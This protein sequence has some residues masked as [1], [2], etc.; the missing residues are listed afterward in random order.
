MLSSGGS[1]VDIG[2]LVLPSEAQNERGFGDAIFRV[3]TPPFKLRLFTV[4]LAGQVK[5]PTGKKVF[6]R[7][8]SMLRRISSSRATSAL[9]RLSSRLVTAFTVTAATLN[10]KTDGLRR[11]VRAFLW[12]ALLSWPLTIGRSLRSEPWTLMS[13]LPSRLDH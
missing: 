5:L 11:R 13:Y 10:L 7:A 6:L 2:G 9:I 4:G 1:A 12:V 3:T 8:R